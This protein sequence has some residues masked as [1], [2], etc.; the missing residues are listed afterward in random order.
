MAYMDDSLWVASNKKELSDILQTATSFYHL[1]N[2]KVNP[3]KSSLIT[4]APSDNTSITFGY[5]NI[6]ALPANSPLK[7]LG[8]W[9]TTNKNHR[10]I[11]KIIIAEINASLRR[12]HYAKIT[13]KQAIYII[14]H[15]IIPRFKYRLYSSYLSHNQL[16]SLRQTMTTL[17]KH[18]AKLA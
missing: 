15:V 11:Q 14:N 9:F 16:N 7:Y 6:Q 3:S 18:K 1:N 17:V 4:N 5:T 2:I 10:S 13:E 8:A 12:L